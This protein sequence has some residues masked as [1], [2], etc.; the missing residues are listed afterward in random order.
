MSEARDYQ[1]KIILDIIEMIE[2]RADPWV[3]ALRFFSAMAALWSVW[4]IVLGDFPES[5]SYDLID[6]LSAR[7]QGVISLPV[8]LACAAA[9]MRSRG[10]SVLRLSAFFVA[11]FWGYVALTFLLGNWQS[12]ATPI[13]VPFSLASAYI[14]TRSIKAK[15]N[16]HD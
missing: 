10:L 9:A 5:R 2:N 15:A 13:Y 6:W 4:L 1:D 3:L 12:T 11:W 7:R 8:M 14:L 16:K